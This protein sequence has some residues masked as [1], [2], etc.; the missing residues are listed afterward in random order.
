MI[1]TYRLTALGSNSNIF[2]L[3]SLPISVV[4]KYER[5]RGERT[6]AIAFYVLF[7]YFLIR[8]ARAIQCLFYINVFSEF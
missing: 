2:V 1:G 4:S 8:K 7:Y 5:K 3:K 6:Q